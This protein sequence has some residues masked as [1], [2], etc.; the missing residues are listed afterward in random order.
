MILYKFQKISNFKKSQI[1]EKSQINLKY[2]IFEFV[3]TLTPKI[4]FFTTLMVA[5][6]VEFTLSIWAIRE[7]TGDRLISSGVS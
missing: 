7:D 4:I 3:F 2:Q 5:R 6:S 1:Y